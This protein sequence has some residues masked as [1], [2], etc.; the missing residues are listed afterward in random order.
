MFFAAKHS[1]QRGERLR[2]SRYVSDDYCESSRRRSGLHILLRC[3]CFV[4]QS[5]V[6]SSWDSENGENLRWFSYS[7][8]VTLTFNCSYTDSA[9]IQDTSWRWQLE[10]ILRS[11]S[12]S[13]RRT[14]NTDVW[15]LKII[16]FYED[17]KT[18]RFQNYPFIKWTSKSTIV[19]ELFWF[20]NV[21]FWFWFCLYNFIKNQKEQFIFY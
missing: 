11:I 8:F 20:S 5:K 19:S 9:W 6:G 21:N 10:T 15:N 2:F 13:T 16:Q 4:E 3:R 17:T 12:T 14:T 1:R 18:L 7:E